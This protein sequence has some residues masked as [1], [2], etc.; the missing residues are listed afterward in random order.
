MSVTSSSWTPTTTASRWPRSPAS[1]S[2]GQADGFRG[3]E[4]TVDDESTVEQFF[5]GGQATVDRQ[6]LLS[7]GGP[8]LAAA[9]AGLFVR[10]PS[11]ELVDI[12]EARVR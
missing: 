8:K 3:F 6:A 4:F 1:R 5:R 10:P 9:N 7:S 11:F 2:R 12:I